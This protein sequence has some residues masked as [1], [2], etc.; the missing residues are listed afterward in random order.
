MGT[1]NSFS[2]DMANYK[3]LVNY[4]IIALTDLPEN[5]STLTVPTVDSTPAT[6]DLAGAMQAGREPKAV[7][8]EILGM[9][10][11]PTNGS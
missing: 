9:L 11:I 10:G 6:F 1:I 4:W 8:A 7:A 2:T 3:G 5:A